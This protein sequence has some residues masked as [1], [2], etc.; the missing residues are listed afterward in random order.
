MRGEM[1]ESIG[2]LPGHGEVGNM[3]GVE[4]NDLGTAGLL[5]HSTLQRG[6]NRTVAQAEHVIT[7]YTGERF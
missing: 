6:R 5:A 2:Q 7:R 1:F 3:V 4:F